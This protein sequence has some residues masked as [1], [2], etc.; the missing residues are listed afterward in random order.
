MNYLIEHIKGMMGE[1]ITFTIGEYIG[2]PLTDSALRRLQS[3][4]DSLVE[5]WVEYGMVDDTF[6]LRPN[7]EGDPP[8]LNAEEPFVVILKGTPSHTP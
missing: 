5:V 1:H 4:L 7:L 8:T 2:I 3:D 6:Y